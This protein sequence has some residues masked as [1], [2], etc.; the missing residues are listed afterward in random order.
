[1]GRTAIVAF[2]S[3]GLAA[4]ATALAQAPGKGS[5]LAGV[6]AGLW[7]LSGI[8]GIK[9]PQ[10]QCVASVGELAQIE[11][12]ERRCQHRTVSDGGTST[13]IQYQCPGGGFGRSKLTALTP[14]SLRIETQG[15][16]D[17]LPFSYVVQARRVGDCA[18]RG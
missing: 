8:P 16:S 3:V 14:R 11:H 17:Q 6:Q 7:E 18:E 1:M 13:V 5:A 10:K 9:T 15:I 12:R 4:G 2:L